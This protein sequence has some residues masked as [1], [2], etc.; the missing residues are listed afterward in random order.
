MLRSVNLHTSFLRRRSPSKYHDPFTTLFHNYVNHFL[1]E[2]LPAFVRVT[3][4]LMGSNRKTSIEEQYAA[5]RPRGKK[6]T[7][8]RR[9]FEVWVVFFQGDVYVL[10]G[11]R[12]RDGW[13]DG[14][15]EPVRLIDI[16]IGILT[17][18]ERFHR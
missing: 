6:P 12:C 7:S 1:R 9:F 11:W 5:V 4:G 10:E 3:V 18:D 16:V 14:E 17:N 15:A 13:A 8:I 2:L